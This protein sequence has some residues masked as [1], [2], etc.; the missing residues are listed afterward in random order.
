MSN[1][2]SH[3][4]KEISDYLAKALYEELYSKNPLGISENEVIRTTK[5]DIYSKKRPMQHISIPNMSNF[6]KKRRAV[7]KLKIF[8][9]TIFYL[10]LFSMLIGVFLI[11]QSNNESDLPRHVG[12]FSIM[13]VL[14]RSMQSEI[15]QNSLIVVR[16]VDPNRLRIGDDI[17]FMITEDRVNTHRIIEVIEYVEEFGGPAFRTQAGGADPHV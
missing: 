16:R 12:G 6:A 10:V 11:T 8:S 14:T 17:T 7:R 1:N 2:E 15:P 5:K 13:R 9:G 3:D 4:F